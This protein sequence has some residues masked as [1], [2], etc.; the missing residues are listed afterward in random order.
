MASNRVKTTLNM[1]LWQKKNKAG[2][3]CF[4]GM[5]MPKSICRAFRK[6]KRGTDVRMDFPTLH[7]AMCSRSVLAAGG[8]YLV[9][10]GCEYGVRFRRGNETHFSRL[11][12]RARPGVLCRISQ[13]PPE[14][15][16][17]MINARL[18]FSENSGLQLNHPCE[19]IAEA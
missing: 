4:G 18:E 6:I 9:G 10:G 14:I 7:V 17:W 1:E 2:H 19:Y 16:S 8:M 13:L 15:P 11:W 12:L 5:A 3:S